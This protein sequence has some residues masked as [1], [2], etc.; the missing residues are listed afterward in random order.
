MELS[1]IAIPVEQQ[2]QAHSVACEIVALFD[3]RSRRSV[4]AG[5]IGSLGCEVY[6]ALA[7]KHG[8]FVRPVPF[9]RDDLSK[10]VICSKRLLSQALARLVEHG[11]LVLSGTRIA[12]MAMLHL[13][14][15]AVQAYRQ[16]EYEWKAQ[17]EKLKAFVRTV[18]GTDW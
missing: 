6:A 7:Q 13:P 15:G 12:P 3:R 8:A 16:E 9:R 17:M 4:P 5:A 11:F 1:A 18:A 2:S 14:N 10:A